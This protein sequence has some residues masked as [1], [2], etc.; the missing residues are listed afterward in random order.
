MGGMSRPARVGGVRGLE[1]SM[2]VLVP[3]SYLMVL[4]S[5]PKGAGT[6]VLLFGFLLWYG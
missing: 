2:W 6:M 4:G 1:A 3:G 5:I